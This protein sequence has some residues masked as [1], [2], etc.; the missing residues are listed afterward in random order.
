MQMLG[1][2]I[3]DPQGVETAG[4]ADG[5]GL[6]PIHTTMQPAKVTSPGIGQLV[7]ESLFG[8][9]IR[10]VGLSGYEIHVGETSYLERARPFAQ[11]I[12]HSSE[13]PES[14]TDGCITLDTR[15]FGTY[16]HGLFDED[17]FRHIFI[18]AAR[19]FHQLAPATG[20]N[21]WREKR[22][23]SL[24]RLATSVNQSLDTPRIL[25]WVGLSYRNSEEAR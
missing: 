15:I 19:E 8:Q 21:N 14:Q 10:K 23:E 25:G 2:Q 18:S 17:N 20:M 13:A 4:C 11:L 5:L 9:P 7:T 3:L 16:L 12:R 1:E 6:L 24:D 22:K